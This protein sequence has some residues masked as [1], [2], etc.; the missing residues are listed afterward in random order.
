MDPSL[1]PT[2]K[3]SAGGLASALSIIIVWV[4]SGAEFGPGWDI[5]AEVAS[6]FTT[7][8][9]FGAAYFVKES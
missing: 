8:L 4:L 6:S 5:P 2:R 7:L 1:V 3:V 9:G